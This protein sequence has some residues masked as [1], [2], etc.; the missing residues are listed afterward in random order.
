[1]H[2]LSRGGAAQEL[3]PRGMQG[4]GNNA[5]NIRMGVPNMMMGMGQGRTSGERQVMTKVD[6]VDIET[7]AC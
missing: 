7:A 3:H 6:N 5:N 2:F 1:M 4:G